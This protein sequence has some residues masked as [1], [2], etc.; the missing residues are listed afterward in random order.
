MHFEWVDE[1][2]EISLDN[3]LSAVISGGLS[4][5]EYEVIRRERA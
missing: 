5:E 3:L 4:E 1:L 2:N